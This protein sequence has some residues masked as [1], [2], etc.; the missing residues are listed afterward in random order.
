[1]SQAGVERGEAFTLSGAVSLIPLG[2]TLQETGTE[3]RVIAVGL[4]LGAGQA[5]LPPEPVREPASP[6]TMRPPVLS[7][8]NGS[9]LVPAQLSQ[10][11]L[12]LSATSPEGG[13]VVFE[14]RRPSL[15]QAGTPQVSAMVPAGALLVGMEG[16]AWVEFAGAESALQRAVEL[17]DGRLSWYVE[18]GGV[19][20]R[21]LPSARVSLRYRVYLGTPVLVLG[22]DSH[23]AGAVVPIDFR[24]VEA[25]RAGVSPVRIQWP[26]TVLS[27]L[28]E[29]ASLLGGFTVSFEGQECDALLLE[30]E[31]FGPGRLSRWA[32]RSRLRAQPLVPACAVGRLASWQLERTVLQL[33]QPVRVVGG[34]RAE[35]LP[36]EPGHFEF[37]VG[38]LADVGP[39]GRLSAREGTILGVGGVLRLEVLP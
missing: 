25:V 17:P 38:E 15:R 10:G 34:G 33:P 24:R 32:Q 18:E 12:R 27:A 35:E 19:I 36:S 20:R 5:L 29:G 21:Y 6:L 9:L 7:P 37:R 3:N 28:G 14:F 13:R 22:G 30:R 11:R 8:A 39:V 1:V 2:N 31:L 23:P 26:D 16:E 4:E